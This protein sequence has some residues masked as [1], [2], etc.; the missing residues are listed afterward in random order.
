MADSA[1][2]VL[3]L[4]AE[5]S[6]R[7]SSLLTLRL[8]R[9]LERREID[10]A[11]VCTHFDGLD[12]CLLKGV[13]LHEIPGINVPV[14]GQLV[15]RTLYRDLK[16]QRPDVIHLQDSR[17]LPQGIRLARKLRR[18]LIVSVGD[19]AEASAFPMKAIA[20]ELKMVISV[21]ESVQ[22]QIPTFPAG[23]AIERRVIM[24]GVGVPDATS[25]DSPLDDER[26]PVVGMAGPL[27]IVKG[28]AFFL[29]ACHRVVEAG[30]NIR[31]VI[32]GSG[33]EERSLR[34]LASSLE[35]SSR[36]TFVDGGVS[37]A[38]Y[39]SAIDIF[40]LP[41]LQ[42]GIG[43]MMLEAMALGRPVV[44][45]GVGGVLSVLEDNVNGLIV[46]PS[47]SRSLAD[48]IIELLENRERARQ[49]A[50]AG[51]S[52]VRTRFNEERMLDELIAVYREVQEAEP[53]TQEAI[54]IMSRTTG[55]WH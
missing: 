41:S 15:L 37:M 6:F 30:H 8:A 47:D 12:P 29:R 18:P 11:L 32:A 53:R 23:L 38:G 51:Q 40:C 19:H 17:L 14:W 10:T 45:S 42:Q 5:L 25:I 49:L 2:R 34:Q 52:L 54:P 27:E 48:R 7:G 20:P 1:L 3:L 36:L 4:D 22:Q 26:P 13:R 43:V 33:P 35:L 21:S 39:L 46:P 28:A 31:I 55:T 44:A 9:G 16:D 50:S 24:P